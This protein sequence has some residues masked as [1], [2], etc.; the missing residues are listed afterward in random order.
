[1]SSTPLQTY[2]EEYMVDRAEKIGST[3]AKTM[4]PVFERC[5]G[6]AGWILDKT[7]IS[8]EG[9]EIFFE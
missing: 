6:E 9:Y 2:N 7:E 1:L 3:E 5:V 4:W 8:T